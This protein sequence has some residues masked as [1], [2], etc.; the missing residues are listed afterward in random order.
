MKKN[1]KSS[2]LVE[3]GFTLIE[4]L[5]VIAIIGILASIVLVSLSGARQRAK[6]AEFKATAS[7]MTASLIVE[8][9]AIS[10]DPVTNVTW[11]AT[12]NSGSITAALA[13]ANGEVSGG[14][15]TSDAVQTGGACVGTFD[16]TGVV[17]TGA[18]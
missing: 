7:S 15:V 1:N 13:C 18:C 9:D 12:N 2:S 11:P 10:P 6:M 17:F 16:Q 4:L 5:I 14:E 8:C 3:H